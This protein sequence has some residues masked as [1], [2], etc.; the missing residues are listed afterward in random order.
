[1]ATA[2]ADRDL[3]AAVVA[4]M[5]VGIDCA[6]EFW[7]GQIEAVFDDSQMTTLGRVQAVKEILNQYRMSRVSASMVGDGHVA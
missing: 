5:A 3:I 6:L 4:E 7:M 2:A 1:M